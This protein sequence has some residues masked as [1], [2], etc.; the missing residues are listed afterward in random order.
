MLPFIDGTA[1]FAQ[2]QVASQGT[3]K[4]LHYDW[5]RTPAAAAAGHAARRVPAN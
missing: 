3:V 5:Q 1:M 2:F 4:F